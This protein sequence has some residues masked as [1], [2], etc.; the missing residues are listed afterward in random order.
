M[1]K[2]SPLGESSSCSVRTCRVGAP[3]F[4]QTRSSD[5]RVCSGASEHNEH[6]T[7]AQIPANR[8]ERVHAGWIESLEFFLKLTES[9][10]KRHFIKMYEGGTK[11]LT[12]NLY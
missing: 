6:L 5:A 2:R 11:S 7:R 9:G 3:L 1:R 12:I 10:L 4:F 8:E